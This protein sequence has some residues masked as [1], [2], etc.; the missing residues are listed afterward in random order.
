MERIVSQHSEERQ[1]FLRLVNTLQEKVFVLE[2][3]LN[4][5][6]A[7]AKKWYAIWK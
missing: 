4:L 5:L 3:Q 1:N 2:N 7:P 6:K